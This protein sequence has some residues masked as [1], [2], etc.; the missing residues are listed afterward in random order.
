M[1]RCWRYAIEIGSGA[2]GVSNLG[3]ANEKMICLGKNRTLLVPLFARRRKGLLAIDFHPSF[4]AIALLI[5]AWMIFLTC[6]MACAAQ[7]SA[8][9]CPDQIGSPRKSVAWNQAG[10]GTASNGGRDNGG[11]VV[12]PVPPASEG[13]HLG[14]WL[15]QHQ[16]MTFAE[17]ERALRTEPGFNRL[18]PARQQRLLQ[19]LQ[20]VDAMPPGQ[21]ERML[22]R[23]ETWERLSPEQRQ[24]VRIGILEV[25]QMPFDRQVMMHRAV[26]DLS[27]FPQAQRGEILNSWEFR[28][29]YSNYE[30]QVLATLMLAQPYEPLRRQ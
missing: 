22:A 4:G 3:V 10:Q 21:R 6:G 17:Q 2:R 14:E 23:L 26:R 13:E 15:R 30:R 11:A 19:R 12:R 29:R 18:P 20:Q 16:N 8:V 1:G 25:H 9:P 24:Q 28:Q 7:C 5:A 27:E